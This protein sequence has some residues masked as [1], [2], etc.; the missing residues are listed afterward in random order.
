MALNRKQLRERL[1]EAGLDEAKALALVEFVIAGHTDTI[2]ALKEE[3]DAAKEEAAK[4]NDIQKALD[5]ANGKVAELEKRPGAEIVEEL[6]RALSDEKAASQKALDE[7][8]AGVEA[9]KCARAKQ[10]AMKSAL[11]AAGASDEAARLMLKGADLSA[12]EMEGDALKDADSAVK[13]Y[14]DEYAGFFGVVTP[15]GVPPVNPPTGAPTDP[16]KWT[17][18]QYYAALRERQKK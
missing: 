1:I 9:E 17:D 8:K 10:G 16:S 4:I 14:K 7:Y 12:L 11:I 2:E 18:E 6:K 15:S 13:P 3:R 5:A